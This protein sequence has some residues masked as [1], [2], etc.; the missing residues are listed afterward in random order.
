[1]LPHITPR[2]SVSEN[3][4]AT[5]RGHEADARIS[6][7]VSGYTRRSAPETTHS[8]FSGASSASF[9][10]F[11]S[12][13]LG[14][15]GN[16]STGTTTP[17][18]TTALTA[19]TQRQNMRL[20]ALLALMNRAANPG[21][22]A[23][24]RLAE[25]GTENSGFDVVDRAVRFEKSLSEIQKLLEYAKNLDDATLDADLTVM[26]MEQARRG[27][28][29]T[30]PLLVSQQ[31]KEVSTQ[32]QSH[33][34]D[35][36]STG[37]GDAG[38]RNRYGRKPMKLIEDELN[39]RIELLKSNQGE[40]EAFQEKILE[41]QKDSSVSNNIIK[42]NK[43]MLAAFF[44]EMRQKA[45]ESYQFNQE[46]HRE[47]VLKKKRS[48]EKALLKKKLEAVIKKDS[49][50]EQGKKREKDENGR[51]Q[52]AQ[53]KWFIV[54]AT[55]ARV[56][57]IQRI[58]E[59]NRLKNMKKLTE[60]HS[61]RVIQKHWRKYAHRKAELRKQEALEKIG[62]VFHFYIL[63]RR[64]EAK[65]LAA[66]KIRQFFKDVHDVSKLMKVVQKYRFSVIGAQ[67]I[68]RR[69]LEI[70][71]AQV[72]V[73]LKYWDKLE[74]TWWAQRKM[75]GGTAGSTGS[76]DG[77]KAKNGKPSKKKGKKP[78][79]DEKDKEKGDKEKGPVLKV[80]E[81]V[82]VNLVTEDLLVR[83][84]AFRKTQDA[85]REQMAK[86]AADL[87]KVPAKRT[88]FTGIKAKVEAK[89][90]EDKNAPKKP[91]FKLLPSVPDMYQII[92][93]GFLSH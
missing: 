58:V 83:K 29:S 43:E 82:R 76:L 85:H 46:R 26:S 27:R 42:Q 1:M 6:S 78:K 45:I 75:H 17:W 81:A 53:K 40:W 56:G 64:M 50:I 8:L 49:M 15:M 68:V 61:A 90:E 34:F 72:A 87:K 24:A 91:V 30:S 62:Q 7:T 89:P 23:F 16:G 32:Q 11:S 33:L 22:D 35:H 88:L 3:A 69:K 48:I 51:G 20:E 59:E 63:R 79:E 54:I 14:I 55:A 31:Y 4:S 73:L 84:K 60:G 71:N 74:P 28:P 67:R 52:L 2:Q 92:N 5:V 13:S 19:A 77:E 21:T 18:L 12:S 65:Y 10:S 80:S 66:D 25:D 47:M 44:P 9:S 86:Y 57:Y 37:G 41:Y 38:G 70:R 93:K 39:K 36:A